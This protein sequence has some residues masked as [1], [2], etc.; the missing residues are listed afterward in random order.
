MWWAHSVVVNVWFSRASQCS[1]ALRAEISR[2]WHNLK[3]TNA[4]SARAELPQFSSVKDYKCIYNLWTKDYKYI[5]LQSLVQFS[6]VQGGIYAL[7]K[8]HMRSTPSRR[9]FSIIGFETVPV[10]VWLTMALPRP[11]KE[12]RLA[13]PLSS[14]VTYVWLRAHPWSSHWDQSSHKQ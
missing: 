2:I 12:D 1:L 6:S 5:N 10:F 8:A 3:Q 9:S 4:Q 11:F 7:G 13:L 14:V